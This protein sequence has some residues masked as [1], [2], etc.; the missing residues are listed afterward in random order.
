M[1]LI[2]YE[3]HLSP[4]VQIA[5]SIKAG[6]AFEPVHKKGVSTVVTACLNNGSSKMDKAALTNMQEDIGLPPDAM[7]NFHSNPEDISFKTRCLSRDL[8]KQLTCLSNILKDPALSDEVVERA[9][10]QAIGH[11]KYIDE[12]LSAKVEHAFVRSVLAATSPYY[13][14]DMTEAIKSIAELEPA[15]IKQ[16]WSENAAPESCTITIAGDIEPDLAARLVEQAFAGW[17]HSTSF[18]NK[19]MPDAQLNPRRILKVMIPCSRQTYKLRVHGETVADKN[20]RSSVQQSFCSPTAALMKHPV[21]L[22]RLIQRLSQEPLIAQSFETDDLESKLSSIGSST[23]WSF[24]LP[25]EPPIVSR[26]TALIQS[27]LKNFGRT[28][29]Q[30]VEFAEAK[31]YLL[32]ALPVRDMSDTRRV[33]SGCIQIS[34]AGGQADLFGRQLE[35]IATTDLESVNKF[36]RDEFRPDQSSLVVAAAKAAM[37]SSQNGRTNGNSASSELRR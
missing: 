26:A 3:S 24:A 13:P 22:S 34:T 11:T 32:N 23:S 16:F 25:V 20:W 31:Q 1:T 18:K 5:G 37:P 36:I 29:L 10:S 7:L 15:D 19:V 12:M 21:F 8:Q 27:E 33:A 4:V 2:T 14:T 9:R 6:A 30:P 17:N 28:A 35:S